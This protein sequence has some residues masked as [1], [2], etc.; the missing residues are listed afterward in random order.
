MTCTGTQE[1]ASVWREKSKTY[2]ETIRL[3]N[4]DVRLDL[5]NDLI[6]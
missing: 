2:L 3:Q 1:A 4:C 6:F 5:L